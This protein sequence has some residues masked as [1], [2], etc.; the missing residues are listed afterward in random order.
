M[1]GH[2]GTKVTEKDLD[3]APTPGVFTGYPVKPIS[4]ELPDRAKLVFMPQADITALE[5][6][7]ITQLFTR[8]I[9]TT[10]KGDSPLDSENYLE[11]HKLKR[12]FVR[13]DEN[14]TIA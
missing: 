6:A 4:L 3:Q 11:D 12:H 7:L 13:L 8:L 2:Y 10:W 9:M 1:A 14:G 5:V